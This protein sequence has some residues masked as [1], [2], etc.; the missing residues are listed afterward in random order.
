M[1]SFQFPFLG[2]LGVDVIE[3]QTLRGLGKLTEVVLD[4]FNA[5]WSV[6]CHLKKGDLP[7]QELILSHVINIGAFLP[8]HPSLSLCQIV[9]TSG[10]I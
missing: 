2:G 5:I 7:F 1:Y 3:F 4:F 9:S 8:Y 10:M 6:P